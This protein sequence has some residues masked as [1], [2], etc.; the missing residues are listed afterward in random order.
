MRLQRVVTL[1]ASLVMVAAR[2]GT[3]YNVRATFKTMVRQPSAV[4]KPTTLPSLCLVQRARKALDTRLRLALIG[5][6]STTTKRNTQPN[7]RARDLR[8]VCPK[9][10]L[11][12]SFFANAPGMPRLVTTQILR[13]QRTPANPKPVGKTVMMVSNTS[14]TSAVAL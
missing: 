5:L 1:L 4:D 6:D 9:F 12:Q 13:C 8:I 11:E 7:T 10:P 14:L 3:P 2:D